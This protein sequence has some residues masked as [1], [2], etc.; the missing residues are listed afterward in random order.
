[1]TDLSAM[2]HLTKDEEQRLINIAK[3]R[4]KKRILDRINQLGFYVREI[5]KE[6]LQEEQK[7][8]EM[9]E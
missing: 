3:E 6:I 8:K 1:M 5:Q 7:L 9:E 4:K 2:L